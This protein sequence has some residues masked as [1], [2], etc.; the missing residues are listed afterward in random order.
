MSVSTHVE[1]HERSDRTIEQT[2]PP[3]KPSS[4]CQGILNLI[5]TGHIRCPECGYP[6]AAA[7]KAF[8]SEW[9]GV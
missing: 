7:A 6:D 4:C 5:Q 3:V 2:S 1:P 9:P 8:W